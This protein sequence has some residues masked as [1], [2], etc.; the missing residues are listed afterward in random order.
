MERK[1][2]A[3]KNRY[4]DIDVRRYQPGPLTENFFH[5]GAHI[6]IG[7]ALIGFV[8]V[9]SP[10]TLGDFKFWANLRLSGSGFQI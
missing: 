2:L 6:A 8:G 5:I 1:M 7:L 3:W 9:L 4:L 10:E